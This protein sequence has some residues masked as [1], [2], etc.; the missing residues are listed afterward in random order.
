MPA[1]PL[2]WAQQQHNYIDAGDVTSLPR[3]P[4]PD[5]AS[6]TLLLDISRLGR[7]VRNN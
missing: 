1:T 4:D 7:S 3:A 5:I 2:S 6:S